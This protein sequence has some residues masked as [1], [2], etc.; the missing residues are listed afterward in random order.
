MADTLPTNQLDTG[1][2]PVPFAPFVLTST[3]HIISCIAASSCACH[4]HQRYKL[5]TH[6][7]CCHTDTRHSLLLCPARS[8]GKV[9]PINSDLLT[10]ATPSPA[11]HPT[12]DCN[13]PWTCHCRPSQIFKMETINAASILT[14]DIAYCHARH[15]H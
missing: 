7:H 5:G 8:K 3:C 12:A 9:Y 15:V 2:H 1:V 13:V 4:C 11:N 10:P 6:C 14:Q